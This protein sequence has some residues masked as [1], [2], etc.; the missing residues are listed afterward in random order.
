MKLNLLLVHTT[1][2]ILTIATHPQ[3]LGGRCSFEDEAVY[4]HDSFD[5]VKN[6]F[7][8]FKYGLYNFKPSPSVH[9]WSAFKSDYLILNITYPINFLHH[10]VHGPLF[11]R[12]SNW[13]NYFKNS[14]RFFVSID[15]EHAENMAGE[16]LFPHAEDAEIFLKKEAERYLSYMNN[17]IGLAK[18]MGEVIYLI[19]PRTHNNQSTSY[20]IT[21]NMRTAQWSQ[22]ST[23]GVGPTAKSG[24]SF[25]QTEDLLYLTGGTAGDNS[26]NDTVFV[27]DI[28]SFKWSRYKIP[29]FVGAADGCLAINSDTLVHAFGR[30][31]Y[32]LSET[33][34]VIDMKGLVREFIDEND[35]RS[36]PT[37]ISQ[38]I[39]NKDTLTVVILLSCIGGTS[40]I[41]L[42]A[43][44]IYIYRIR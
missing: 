39:Q 32:S 19:H 38:P 20:F 6:R 42:S 23:S 36:Y 22:K 37:G 24:F 10:P 5:L 21:Y 33:T 27:F 15:Q 4:Y 17:Q 11:F 16:L 8:P 30:I 12:L 3:L 44:Y 14:L 7:S 2:T 13:A 26:E 25:F 43:T 40:I 35:T 28:N 1:Y 29:G 9:S 41:L 31:N 18:I 34:Q